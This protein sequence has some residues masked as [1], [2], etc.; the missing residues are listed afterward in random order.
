MGPIE[1]E[2]KFLLIDTLYSYKAHYN[3]GDTWRLRHTALSIPT[4]LLGAVVTGIASAGFP[5]LVLSSLSATELVLVA[6]VSWW[7]PAARAE[8]SSNAGQDLQ[9]FHED[10]RQWMKLDLPH[11]DSTAAERDLK[12]WTKKKQALN[13][14]APPFA[15]GAYAEAKKGIEAGQAKHTQEEMENL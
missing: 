8:A 4:V 10:F 11:L 7:K 12:E 5:P 9:S 3:S 2:A 14:R 1:E 6:L 13:K 15:R